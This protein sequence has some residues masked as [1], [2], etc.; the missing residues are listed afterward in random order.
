[1][2]A[3]VRSIGAG[4]V[5][6]VRDRSA[7]GYRRTW[8][9]RFLLLG[10]A[11]LIAGSLYGATT[12]EAVFDD[13][14]TM[15]RYG[16]E[17]GILSSREGVP[18][19][20]PR[21]ILLV[22]TTENEGIAPDDNLRHFRSDALL[23][24]TIMVLRVE[25]DAGQAYVMSINR[26][27]WV[28]SMGTR[29]NAALQFGGIGGL[30]K[31]IGEFLQ[32]PIDNFM[33]VNFAGFRKV[34]DQLDGVPVYFPHAA[35]DLGSFFEIAAGCHVLNGQQALDYVRSRSYQQ[36]IGGSW[37]YDNGNDYVRAERQRDFLVLALDR[38]VEKGARNP[39]VLQRLLKTAGDSQAIKLDEFM[40]FE[41]LLNLGRSFADFD[42]E[43]LQR[44]V[45]PGSGVVIGPEN[46]SVIK[47]DE[48]A[49]QPVLDIFRG[50]GNTLEPQQVT[51]EITEGRGKTNDFVKADTLLWGRGFRIK[52]PIQQGTGP[53]EAR[54]IV[55][56]SADQRNAALLVS[57]YLRA[58]PVYQEVTGLRKLTLTL[59]LDY[60]GVNE[61]PVPEA[62]LAGKFPGVGGAAAPTTT[63]AATP[64]VTSAAVPTSTTVAAPSPTSGANAP[65]T[66]SGIY[67]KPPDGVSCK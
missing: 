2:G 25:P 18:P 42:P 27:V 31:I 59:G 32:I 66:T 26:D 57:R 53:V 19:S 62:A 29:I 51:V 54:S 1:V 30:V 10:C 7:V 24:D 58:D 33:I 63:V 20:A 60:Q 56:Y 21:N 64:R 6:P 43:N 17:T 9:Q 44:L 46:A 13:L 55:R 22:G 3:L 11:G 34:V 39:A 4:S 45:L 23:A 36:R 14:A 67:G 8:P 47:V 28:P 50:N 16:V 65:T 40:T 15:P 37:V 35:R 12:I 41:E 49:A 48:A 5:A 38:A 52:G 61:N